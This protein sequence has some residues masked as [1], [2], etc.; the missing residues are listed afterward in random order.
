MEVHRSYRAV[1]EVELHVEALYC[2]F[3]VLR[4]TPGSGY[5][6]ALDSARRT[7][8][9]LERCLGVIASSNS[10]S[11]SL[12]IIVHEDPAQNIDWDILGRLLTRFESATPCTFEMSGFALYADYANTPL[13][14]A[15]E[16][17]AVLRLRPTSVPIPFLH[18]HPDLTIIPIPFYRVIAQSIGNLFV[19]ENVETPVGQI[20]W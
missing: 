8:S 2:R 16:L 9:Q 12:H 4:L 19:N 6:S 5:G 11:D 10:S 7:R 1:T 3:P 13:Q 17:Q 15:Y 20:F 18:D 14:T